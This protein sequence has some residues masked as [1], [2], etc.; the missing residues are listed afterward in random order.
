MTLRDRILGRWW[1]IVFLESD[2]TQRTTYVRAQ[3]EAT[4]RRKATLKMEA[5]YTYGCVTK[6]L[7]GDRL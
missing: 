3:D 2:G 4:A 7:R 1:F 5:S 6:C